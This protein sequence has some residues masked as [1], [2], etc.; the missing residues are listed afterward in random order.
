MPVENKLESHINEP[1]KSYIINTPNH[2][3]A[4]SNQEKGNDELL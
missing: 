1:I 2:N 3:N 4:T